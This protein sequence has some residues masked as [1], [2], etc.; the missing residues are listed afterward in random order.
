MLHEM[1]D[2]LSERN[3]TFV[4]EVIHIR[5]VCGHN[6]LQPMTSSSH[7]GRSGLSALS[8]VQYE[9]VV[10][11]ALSCELKLK[12]R[13]YLLSTSKCCTFNPHSCILILIDLKQSLIFL[14]SSAQSKDQTNLLFCTLQLPLNYLWSRLLCYTPRSKPAE[15]RDLTPRVESKLSVTITRFNPTL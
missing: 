8:F 1:W 11:E 5:E 7:R 4:T 2:V 12:P 10:T 9:T 15:I 6:L 14:R 3:A 13:D